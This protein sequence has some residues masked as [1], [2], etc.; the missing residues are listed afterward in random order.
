MCGT[1]CLFNICSCGLM[2][3][4]LHLSPNIDLITF[5]GFI[6]T[7][8]ETLRDLQALKLFFF[9]IVVPEAYEDVCV[10]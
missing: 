10:C 6:V 5:Y 7:I 3:S 4:S 9:T 8:S 2:Y 1:L